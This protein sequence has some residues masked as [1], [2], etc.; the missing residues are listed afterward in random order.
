MVSP[1]GT[2]GFSVGNRW[3]LL[4]EPL[5]SDR[6]PNGISRWDDRKVPYISLSPIPAINSASALGSINE[7]LVS[8]GSVKGNGTSIYALGIDKNTSKVGFIL[9]KSGTSIPAGKAYLN[10]VASG[11]E[12][13]GFGDEDATGIEA[14]KQNA[15]ADN[16][17]FN[18]A[19]QRVTQ[20]TKGL[21]IVNGKKVIVK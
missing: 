12:F 18:L 9:V 21:Y 16:Q 14:V 10:I 8:D 17:Y 19:G 15:K 5:V 6:A 20:P 13:I 2:D 7:L 3:F 4:E 11:R 1:L